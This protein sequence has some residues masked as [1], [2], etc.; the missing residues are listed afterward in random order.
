MNLKKN[1]D[2]NNNIISNIKIGVI[3][4]PISMI[5][6]YVYVP[7]AL[8]YLGIEKYGVWATI[9]TILS[10][11]S[12]FDIGIG[13]GLRNKLTESISRKDGKSRKLVSSA[14]AFITIIMIFTIIVF[15][16]VASFL[17]WN[18]VFGVKNASENLTYIVI[19]N[20]AFMALNFILS[21]CKNVLYALQQAANVSVM[22]L[23]VQI[24]NLCGVLIAR[25]FLNSSL[26]VMTI[27]YG[28]SMMIVNLSISVWIYMQ[29]ADVRPAIKLINI[30][31]GKELTN[32]GIQFFVIQICALVLFTTDSIIISLLYGAIN[33]TPYNTVNKLFNTIIGLFSIISTPIWSAVTKAKAEQH[34]DNIKNIITKLHLAMVPFAV[35]IFILILTFRFV[36]KIWLGQELEYTNELIIFG[37]LYAILNIWTNT[38]GTI[39]NG[40]GILKEQ[41]VMALA[42]AIV[43]LPLSLFFAQK[44]NMGCAGILLGTNFALLISCIYLPLCIKKRISSEEK[45]I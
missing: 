13:N 36:S 41:M 20:V 35:G 3:C 44:M 12:F 42:Q 22:E 25:Q 6:S 16:I 8:N 2:M 1:F 28:I 15:A 21:I 33:V 34:F 5:I 17:D 38:Y 37:G 43:N 39:A 9:L 19:I 31:T 23:L 11:I 24:I 32:L 18:I 7:I 26:F 27:I 14:Y 10:W 40:L 4:K 29:N 30:N 45:R